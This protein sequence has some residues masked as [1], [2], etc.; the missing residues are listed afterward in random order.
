MYYFINGNNLNNGIIEI[1]ADTKKVDAEE[2]FKHKKPLNESSVLVSINGTIGNIAFYN[3]EPVILGKSAC[4]F[5]LRPILIKGYIW[6]IIRSDY[7]LMYAKKAAT[8]STIKNLSLQAMRMMPLP[9]PPISIQHR[10]V[11]KIE[12]VF[13]VIN[14]LEITK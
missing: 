2:Y 5:N 11:E 3:E 1:K 13:S 10:I 4:Y 8:G 14:Q 9:I 7:F 12:D 6:L